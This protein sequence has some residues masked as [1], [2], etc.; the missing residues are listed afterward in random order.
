[1]YDKNWDKYYHHTYKVLKKKALW[2]V[3]PEEAVEKDF[4]TFEVHMDATLPMIDLGCGTGGQADYLSKKYKTIIAVDVSKEAIFV[5][6]AENNNDRIVFDVLDITK[7][8]ENYNFLSAEKEYNIYMRGVLHQIKDEDIAIFQRN[9]LK[10]LGEK[11]NMYCVEVAD[12]IKEVLTKEQGDFSQLPKRMQ[13]VF[14]SNLPPRGLSLDNIYKYF[15]E[16]KFNIVL[17]GESFLNTNIK[18]SDNK[19]IK[20]PAIFALVTKK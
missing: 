10:L 19:S 14:I 12:S 11:G 20:I 7:P 5:A 6:E 15:S 16:D 17:S 2:D 3:S 13:Q 8:I 18:Y 1:M 4:E 9:I